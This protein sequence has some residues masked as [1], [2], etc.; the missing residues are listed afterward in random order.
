M[1]CCSQDILYL[2]RELIFVARVN[3]IYHGSFDGSTKKIEMLKKDSYVGK[4]SVSPV[5][6]ADQR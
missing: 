1:Y 5:V 2:F 6:T 3:G 4:D